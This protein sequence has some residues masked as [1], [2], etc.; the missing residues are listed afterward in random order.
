MPRYFL[1]RLGRL[2]V[3]REGVKLTNAREARLEAILY[4]AGTVNAARKPQLM[5]RSSILPSGPQ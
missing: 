2:D 5:R 3:D 4:A 1:H